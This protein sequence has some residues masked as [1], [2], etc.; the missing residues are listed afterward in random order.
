MTPARKKI[1]ITMT[2]MHIGGAE[3]S[4]LGLLH[5]IDYTQYDV[6]LF[7][8]SHEGEFMD[9]IPPQVNLLPEISAY[10]SLIQPLSG[11]KKNSLWLYLVKKL[12]ILAACIHYKCSGRK[13]REHGITQYCESF[14]LPFLPPINRK[15]YDL[16]ISFLSY[17]N[18]I[19]DKLSATCK[20]GWYHND[21]HEAHPFLKSDFKTWNRLDGIIHVSENALS[22]FVHYHPS[23]KYK[24]Y[25]IENIL[26]ANYVRKQAQIQIKDLHRDQNQIC[27]LT[28]G[29]LCEQK[30]YDRAIEACY[31]LKKEGYNIQWIAIGEGHL[32]PQLKQKVSSLGLDGDFLFLGSKSNPYPYIE[33]CDIYV[34]PSNFEEKSVSVREAQILKKPVIV[35]NYST[36]ASQIKNGIDGIITDMNAEAV[37]QAITHLINHPELRENLSSNCAARDYG[38][39]GEIN[40]IYQMVP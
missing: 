31:L 26:S 29:R 7:L 18:I 40:H 9:M 3:R 12:A 39:E 14:L 8:F 20:L 13:P 11:L 21:Y 2:Y 37:A 17:H 22:S 32:E 30:A 27:L 25:V 4:L 10:K 36:A 38:N 28:V 5:A 23:L 19:S 34:Q 24:T 1:I 35:T 33:W 16:A 6:D 15:S